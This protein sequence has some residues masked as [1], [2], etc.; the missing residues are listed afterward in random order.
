LLIKETNEGG[1]GSESANQISEKG[2]GASPEVEVKMGVSPA[3]QASQG[4]SNT[5]GSMYGFINTCQ[6]YSAPQGEGESISLKVG[7]I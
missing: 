7:A 5:K 1:K 6:W 2:V 4:T 3:W